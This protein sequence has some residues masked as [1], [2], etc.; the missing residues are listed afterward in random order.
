M[1]CLAGF[2]SDICLIC[3]ACPV[4]CVV[5]PGSSL[6]R[7]TCLTLPPVRCGLIGSVSDICLIL[8]GT[9]CCLAGSVSDTGHLSDITP[10]PLSGVFLVGSVSDMYR[11]SV[12]QHGGP[13]TA[14]GSAGPARHEDAAQPGAADPG[15]QPVGRGRGRAQG[16]LHDVQVSGSG[17][18]QLRRRPITPPD[19][20]Q[21]TQ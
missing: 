18:P 3:T 15:A 10:W 13:G 17:S 14:V 19:R 9:M 11:L 1:C 12:R 2:V 20:H 21:P 5:W 16:V 4:L 8:A 7:E 6:T